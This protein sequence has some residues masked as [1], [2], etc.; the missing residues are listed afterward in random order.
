MT[1]DELDFGEIGMEEAESFQ[2]RIYFL[3]HR[4]PEGKVATYG[5]LAFLAGSSRAARAVGHALRALNRNSAGLRWHRVINAAGSVSYK[6]DFVRATLQMEEL[7]REGISF[8][9][10][11]K[12]DLTIYGWRPES[13]YWAD[14]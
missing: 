6:S 7:Q 2:D 1:E 13:L 11:G 4:I 10:K 12:C 8:D 9:S 5:Q 14:E 3:T